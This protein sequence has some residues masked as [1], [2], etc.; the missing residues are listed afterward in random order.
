M[1]RAIVFVRDGEPLAVVLTSNTRAAFERF[2]RE[3]RR[4]M[5]PMSME[6]AV[7]AANEYEQFR[8]TVVE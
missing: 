8:V 4:H 3:L 5:G 6:E 1:R 2:V 7:S